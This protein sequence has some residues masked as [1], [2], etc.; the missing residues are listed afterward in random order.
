MDIIPYY[1][2]LIVKTQVTLQYIH[3]KW[4]CHQTYYSYK[5]KDAPRQVLNS[6]VK[7]SHF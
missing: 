6:I 4:K 1:I 3:I 7:S 5:I 2:Q